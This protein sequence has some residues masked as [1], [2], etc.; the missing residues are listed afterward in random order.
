VNL[1]IEM[2]AGYM[3]DLSERD[4]PPMRTVSDT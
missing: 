4:P 3:I 2:K 1:N